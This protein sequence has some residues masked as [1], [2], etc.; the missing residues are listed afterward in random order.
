M[1]S[2]SDV[3]GNRPS[4]Q[5]ELARLKNK[6]LMNYEVAD[7]I[8]KNQLTQN[9]IDQ[10][11]S[12]LNEFVKETEKFNI[13]ESNYLPVLV[14]EDGLIEVTYR[15]TEILLKRRLLRDISQRVS[16][17][18][19]PQ[20]LKQASWKRDVYDQIANR[21]KGR[22][23]AIMNIQSFIAQEDHSHAKGVYL[24]GD[25]GIGKSFLLAAMVNSLAEQGVKSQMIHFPTFISQPN[26]AA[27]EQLDEVKTADL[28]VIDDIGG[29]INSVWSRDNVLQV[30][31][32]YR[33]DNVLPTFF[34]SNHSM[35]NLE[36][37]LSKTSQG[38]DTWSAK[39]VM[40]RIKFLSD[41]IH[42][43]GEN[44]RHG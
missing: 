32:Q 13:S 43:E 26:F 4:N 9:Q 12:K 34:T 25:F 18:G 22:M 15:E 16:M 38:V 3:L 31:L 41:E 42:L 10:G 17:V 33:M 24:Y 23:K 1:K 35:Q 27:S 39:R 20:K 30:L 28:L 11:L 8:L 40:E 37:R 7:F 44:R 29:E 5:I 19:L 2:I 14:L 6:I 21:D 36:E